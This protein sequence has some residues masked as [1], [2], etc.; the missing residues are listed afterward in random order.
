MS[1]G[2]Q[3]ADELPVALDAMGGD[4]APD[5]N[6]DGAVEA[7]LEDGARVV[8]VGDEA[9]LRDAL[10]KRGKAHLADGKRLTIRHA[11]EVVAM[12]EKPAAVVRKKKNSS[13]RVACD[14]VK[15]GEAVG[16]LSA[17]NSGAMMAMALFVFGRIDGVIRPAIATVVPTQ[18][19]PSILL[20]AGANTTCDPEHLFQFAV[21]GHT[22]MSDVLGIE[23]PTIG[24]VANGEEDTK[25]T[26]LTRSALAL[27]RRTD[28]PLMGHCEGSD[29]ATGDVRVAVCDGF[30]GNVILKTGEGVLK[31]ILQFIRA[32]Y[33]NAGPLGKLGGALSKPV[34]NALK[35]KLDPREH[36]AAPLLGLKAPAFIAHG[37]SDDHAIRQAIG[38]VRKHV[39]N[40][41]TQHIAEAIAETKPLL[42]APAA[43]A[44]A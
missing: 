17:G 4:H 30:T 14:L 29:I 18:Q 23:K 39:R 19:G 33:E 44:S 28:L 32:E 12:D 5:V 24:V 36:G 37:N 25:G 1:E 35:E 20:D 42:E 41:V 10:E 6:I 9:V 38:L 2:R 13:M 3:K 15:N 40:D 34:F 7:V 26:D 27:L 16:A 11:P 21:M 31:M 8:L 22:Y 43:D